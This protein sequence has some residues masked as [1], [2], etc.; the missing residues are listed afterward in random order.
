MATNT[1]ANELHVIFGTGP[2]GKW[3]ARE[4]VK[5]GKQVRMINRSGKLTGMP[6]RVEVVKGDAYNR[7]LNVEQTKGAVA[8]YQCAQPEYYEWTTKFMPMQTAILDAAMQNGAKFIAA[9]NVYMYGD[10]HGVPMTESTPYNAHTK[11]GKVRQIMTE[12]IFAAHAAGK[13]RAATV[14][15]SD[16]FG[17]DDMIYTE[18][19]FIP[20]QQGKKVNALGKLDQPH[21]WTYAP[22]FGNALAIVGTHDEAL[23]QAWH[24]PS[25]APRTQQQVFDEISAQIGKPVSAQVGGKAMLSL[26]GLFNKTLAEMPEMLYEFTQPFIV[27]SSKFQCTFGVQPTPFAQQIAETLAFAR[28]VA[29]SHAGPAKLPAV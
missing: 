6:A 18:N 21:T 19:I 25:E 28:L 8:I 22:D 1:N 27:D 13:V 10:T 29:D 7:D 2:L 16:F 17:P 9:E 3:T 4:L 24:A 11:K 26:I 15:G 14:R 20:V 12:A 23:G 5:L